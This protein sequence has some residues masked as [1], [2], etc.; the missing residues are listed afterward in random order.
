MPSVTTTLPADASSVPAARRWVE[1][2]LTDWGHPDVGWTAASVISELATNCHLHARTSF[3]LA[4]RRAEEGHFLLEISDGSPALPR[5]RRYGLDST[6]GRGL[7][8]VDQ[9]SEAWGVVR[10]DDGRGKTVWVRLS[11]TTTDAADD[12]DADVDA[13]LAAFGDDADVVPLQGRGTAT[14]LLRWAA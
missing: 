2:V 6:T 10:H 13:L 9:L 14:A 7:A 11:E 12:P 8:L 1:S 5:Q 3:T 4:V